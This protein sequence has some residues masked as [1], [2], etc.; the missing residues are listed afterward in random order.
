[1][2][3]LLLLKVFQFSFFTLLLSVTTACFLCSVDTWSE[4][5]GTWKVETSWKHSWIDHSR[6]SLFFIYITLN[7]N[8][9]L[10]CL[11]FWTFKPF[12]ILAKLLQK[13]CEC[14]C[15]ERRFGEDRRRCEGDP[16]TYWQNRFL[17]LFY[18]F[19]TFFLFSLCY[20]SFLCVQFFF[21]VWGQPWYLLA[22]QV[23]IH[24]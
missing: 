19:F 8:E 17:T 24:T 9:H 12:C 5:H 16:G 13:T 22:E 10:T 21:I 3:I 23:K 7:M 2:F 6:L 1:M 14:E 18:F 11:P 20:S 4:E 15:D